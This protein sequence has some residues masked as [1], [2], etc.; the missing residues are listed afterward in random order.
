[1]T[2]GRVFNRPLRASGSWVVPDGFLFQLQEL[3]LSLEPPPVSTQIAIG[4]NHAMA[5]HNHGHRIGGT[6]ASHSA[7]GPRLANFLRDLPV[8]ACCPSWNFAERLPDAA[9]KGRSLNIQGDFVAGCIPLDAG[10]NLL[11][12]RAS[13]G[14][15]SAKLACGNSARSPASSAFE[16][17]PSRTTQMPRSVVPTSN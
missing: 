9:L 6:C 3:L 5:G 12:Q 8:G 10:Y 13:L 4:A 15:E 14:F 1:M 17:S 16:E 11:T 7:E 2:P